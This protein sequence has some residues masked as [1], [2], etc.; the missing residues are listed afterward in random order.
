MIPVV[1]NSQLVA[2]VTVET[3]CAEMSEM[4]THHTKCREL[5]VI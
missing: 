4:C 2:D 1:H 5:P 3:A